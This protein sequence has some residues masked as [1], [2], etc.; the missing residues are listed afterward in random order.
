MSIVAPPIRPT[1]FVAVSAVIVLA[2]SACASSVSDPSPSRR[3]ATEAPS[4]SPTATA[5]PEPE[6]TAT[7]VPTPRPGTVEEPRA[8]LVDMT[9][10]LRFDPSRIEV[11]AGETIQFVLQNRSQVD[12]DFTLGDE[13]AQ[14]HHEEEMANFY[15]DGGMMHGH[16]ETSAV[17]VAAGETTLFVVTFD[18]PGEVLIGC[19][20]P[21][22]YDAG[23]KGSVMVSG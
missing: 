17:L 5:T 9:D 23:M 20:I 4:P 13:M 15:E 22:H 10:E 3:P 7:P 16:D 14:M 11:R 18:A 1:R 6:P 2:A 19:H 12:H 21:G 8:I